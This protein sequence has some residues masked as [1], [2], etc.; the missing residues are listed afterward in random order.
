MVRHKVRNRPET[1][2][3]QKQKALEDSED[4]DGEQYRC[5]HSYTYPKQ[6]AKRQKRCEVKIKGDVQGEGMSTAY[7]KRQAKKRKK[8]TAKTAGDIK[9]IGSSTTLDA[10]LEEESPDYDSDNLEEESPDCDSDNLEEESPDCNIESGAG[11]L[12][13]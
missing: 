2:S 5:A 6:E 4:S 12:Q 9:G 7:S 11:E 10:N 1:A 8:G 3:Q 13:S